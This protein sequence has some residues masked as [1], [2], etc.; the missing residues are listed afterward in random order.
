MCESLVAIIPFLNTY[1]V[2]KTLFLGTQAMIT[3]P[4]IT[5]PMTN[6]PN[7]HMTFHSKLRTGR[8]S[9]NSRI[10]AGVVPKLMKDESMITYH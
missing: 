9:L 3:Q 10:P 8:G 6:A 1:Q 7:H 5:Q 4:M 2:A